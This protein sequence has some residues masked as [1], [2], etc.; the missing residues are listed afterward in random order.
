LNLTTLH[1]NAAHNK[2]NAANYGTH[3]QANANADGPE[4]IPNAAHNK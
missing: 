4:N 1:E 3:S 2:Q